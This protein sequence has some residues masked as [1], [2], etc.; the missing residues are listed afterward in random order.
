MANLNLKVLAVS[1]ALLLS[2]ACGEMREPGPMRNESVSIEQKK[3]ELVRVELKL[4]AGELT[5]EPGAQK[6]MEGEFVY[7]VPEWKP[8]VRFDETSFRGHLQVEQPAGAS[9][10]GD[11]QY[12]WNLRFND[13][14]PMDMVVN[15]GAGEAR[16]NLGGLHLR[17]LEINMGVGELNLDLRGTPQRDYEVRVHGGVGEATI[18]LPRDVGVVADAR[19]GIG[20]IDVKNLERQGHQYVNEAYGNARNTIRLEVRGGIGEINLVAE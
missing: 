13:K 1:L 20:S 7:N 16:L 6:L 19:G 14:V 10:S 17:S 3:S 12:D 11:T 15:L 18:R 9:A 4:K 8:V 5:V 2:A